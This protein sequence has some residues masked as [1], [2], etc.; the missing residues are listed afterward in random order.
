MKIKISVLMMLPLLL[1]PLGSASAG[2]LATRTSTG[3][4][5]CPVE[6]CKRPKLPLDNITQLDPGD[7]R[8]DYKYCWDLHNT[9]TLSSVF[10][11]IPTDLI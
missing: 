2:S 1:I 7:V 10:D 9:K 6:I 3:F 11:N 4:H 8:P 5:R